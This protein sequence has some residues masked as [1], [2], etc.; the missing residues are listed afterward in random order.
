[1]LHKYIFGGVVSTQV[2]ERFSYTTAQSRQMNGTTRETFR[3][4]YSSALCQEMIH[5]NTTVHI[6][7]ATLSN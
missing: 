6:I 7:R 5:M 3:F 4:I 2:E 1:M